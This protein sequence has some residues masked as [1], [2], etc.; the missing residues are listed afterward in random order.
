MSVTI[1]DLVLE[2]CRKPANIFGPSFFDQHL[3][4]VTEYAGCLAARLGADPEVVELAALLH[5][6]SAVH[7]A[8]T[9]P[10]HAATSAAEASRLLAGKG[11]AAAVMERV[12]LCIA[13]HSAPVQ[14]GC[15]SP[16][17]ICVSNADAM[18]RIARPV[19][20]GYVAYGVRKQGFEEG[21]QWLRSLLENDWNALVQ[22]AKELVAAEYGFAQ[23]LLAG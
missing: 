23:T 8:A 9:L 4:V 14:I 5:D 15:G 18:S 21:R 22:P 7:D 11:Y 17:E 12:A 2:D 20:W 1:R 3:A 16:E 10:R 6:I 13:S 19:Y